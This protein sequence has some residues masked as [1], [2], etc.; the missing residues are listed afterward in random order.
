M[1][2]RSVWKGLVKLL[3]VYIGFC[4]FQTSLCFRILTSEQIAMKAAAPDG[5]PP[6]RLNDFP[7]SE[8]GNE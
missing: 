2:W 5:A 7:F 6:R 8:H 4:I 3:F 1:A